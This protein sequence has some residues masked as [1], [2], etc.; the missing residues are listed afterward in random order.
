MSKKRAEMRRKSKAESKL[1]KQISAIPY[2]TGR[3]DAFQISQTTGVKIQTIKAWCDDRVE[4]IWKDCI[5]QAND[6]LYRAENYMALANVLM[7]LKA[8]S[9]TFGDL[10]TVQKGMNRL[11]KNL[12][13]A[14]QEIDRIGVKAAYDQLMREYGI[15]ELE[16]EDFDINELWDSRQKEVKTFCKVMGGGYDK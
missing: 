16:F 15:G 5:E 13:P 14:M 4:E 6:I 2:D 3:M 1:A 9:M 7:M 10:K 12:N 8:V 11:I